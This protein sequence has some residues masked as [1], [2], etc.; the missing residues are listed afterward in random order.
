MAKIENWC[1]VHMTD[2][3]YEAPETRKLYFGGNVFGHSFFEDGHKIITSH[4]V[5]FSNGKF[6]TFSGTAI[7]LSL[8]VFFFIP[9]NFGIDM[10]G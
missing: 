6:Y 2:N 10:T 7:I 3:G 4:I 8:L 1:L 5:S 9:K